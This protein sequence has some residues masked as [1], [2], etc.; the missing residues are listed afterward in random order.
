MNKNYEELKK[1]LS[2][3]VTNKELSYDL[4]KEFLHISERRDIVQLALLEEAEQHISESYRSEENYTDKPYSYYCTKEE[5]EYSPTGE[6]YAV[7]MLI[8]RRAST[9]SWWRK[10]IAEEQAI[11]KELQ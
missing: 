3:A 2:N 1:F 6:L 4:W 8:E 11:E 7:L 10:K 5:W 9:E